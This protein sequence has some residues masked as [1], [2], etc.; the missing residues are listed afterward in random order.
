MSNVPVDLALPMKLTMTLTIVMVTQL[1]CWKT[2]DP[3]LF[4]AT[5]E[6]AQLLSHCKQRNVSLDSAQWSLEVLAEQGPAGCGVFIP[7][8]LIVI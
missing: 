8:C 1:S 5:G 2:Q 3:W 6:N 4:E 7:S